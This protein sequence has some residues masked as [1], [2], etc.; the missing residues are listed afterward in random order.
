MLLA[1]LMAAAGCLAWRSIDWGSL[2]HL[3]DPTLIAHARVCVAISVVFFLFSLPLSLTHRVLG[4]YQEVHL[5]NY[6]SM[7]NSLLGL[8]SIVGTILFHGGLVALMLAYCS[9]MLLGGVGLNLWISIWN[10]PWMRPSPGHVQLNAVRALF[11]QG[12][13]FFV[14]QLTTLV[15]FNSDN[16]VIT[17]FL[18][19]SEVTPYSISWR[20]VGYA[21]MFQSLLVPSFWPAFTEAYKNREMG[22]MNKTYNSMVR[23]TMLLVSAIACC[24]GLVG[25]EVIRIWAGEAAVPNHMLLWTMVA[26]AVMSTFTTNQALLLTATGRL[27]LEATVAVIAAVLNLGLSVIL[28]QRIGAE[29]VV[30]ATV[31]SFAVCMVIPQQRE[32]RRVLAG[33]FLPAREP[34]EAGLVQPV[35]TTP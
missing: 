1:T 10:K 12:I 35:G 8:I 33:V 28:V 3:S 20:L 29:G 31:V 17:H 32:V 30:L 9:A 19:A 21:T 15:V 4:G 6:F 13:L 22:W 26:W 18:G 16:L 7:V 23:Q 34:A 25:R 14:L 2:L 5:A 27:R 24:M 11:G